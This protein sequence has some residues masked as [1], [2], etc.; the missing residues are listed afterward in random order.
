MFEH[1]SQEFE[2]HLRP[3]NNY[4]PKSVECVP[5]IIGGMRCIMTNQNVRLLNSTF[6]NIL[7]H[8]VCTFSNAGEWE[9]QFVPK[10]EGRGCHDF[11][12]VSADIP[13]TT[14]PY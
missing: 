9:K 10:C 5:P 13:V 6:F 1:K 8:A 11:S 4:T 14:L 7:Y 12:V 2:E 3:F